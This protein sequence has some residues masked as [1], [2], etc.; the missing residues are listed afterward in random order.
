MKNKL[1]QLTIT[2][3]Q[4]VTILVFSFVIY[5][6]VT[7]KDCKYADVNCDGIVDQYDSSEVFYNFDEPVY[8]KVTIIDAQGIV[9]EQ[10]Q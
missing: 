3:I 4:A 7:Y 8:K 6:T 2:V 5:T 10:I 9:K 1:L